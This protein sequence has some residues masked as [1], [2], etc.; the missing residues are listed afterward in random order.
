VPI[1]VR[2]KASPTSSRLVSAS[3]E[4]LNDLRTVMPRTTSPK[5][6][7]SRCWSRQRFV[8]LLFRFETQEHHEY[9]QQ[10]HAHQDDARTPKV[11]QTQAIRAA[12]PAPMSPRPVTART[13]RCSSRSRRRPRVQSCTVASTLPCGPEVRTWSKAPTPKVAPQWAGDP[14]SHWIGRPTA[15]TRRIVAT[16]EQRSGRDEDRRAYCGTDSQQRRQRDGL[17]NDGDRCSEARA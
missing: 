10:Q 1:V 2:C 16:D 11:V 13:W 8:H 4:R 12:A 6:P 17:A 15:I 14:R 3:L 7:A 9:R 5:Y